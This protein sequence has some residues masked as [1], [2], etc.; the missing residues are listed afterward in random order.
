MRVALVHDQLS[1]FGGAERVLLVLHEM[2]PEASIYT[3]FV[4]NGSPAQERFRG[5]EIR[6]SWAQHIPLY[7]SKLY[8]P[9][10][11][12]LP[13]VWENFDF[14]DYDLVISSDGWSMCKGILTGTKT[15]HISYIHTPPRY[16]YGYPTSIQWQKHWPVRLYGNIVNYHLREYDFVAAQRPD[17]LIA[18]SEN[19]RKR[20]QKFYNRDATV[21]YP[22]VE[23]SAGPAARCTP[24]ASP[25]LDSRDY[26]LI[27]SR[28]VG[29]KGLRLAVQACTELELP[30]KVVGGPAGWSGELRE[31]HRI[32]GPTIEYLGRVTDEELVGLYAGAEAF[33]ATSQDEDFGI[34]VVEAQM[35]GV[36][37]IAYRGGGYLETVVEGKT[38]V[39][40]D[41]Y[42][43][44]GLKQ[45]I[46]RYKQQ[47]TSYKSELIRKHAQKFS[48][49]RFKKE[50]EKVIE[51]AM[52]EKK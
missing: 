28:I 32:S 34:T 1:E 48:K 40:F 30:L 5:A 13:L 44:R 12:L 33:L 50:M 42:S 26:F 17:V 3:A 29:G 19:I 6:P 46:A 27:V 49:E 8:S 52:R 20:I 22:P 14:H 16:L 7:S 24:L 51:K 41:E 47:A 36:P 25:V 11:F 9:L 43:V 4:R 38:G 10:R 35:A 21:I 37:V 15:V 45:G 23:L 18:N 31:L 2:F 39:F